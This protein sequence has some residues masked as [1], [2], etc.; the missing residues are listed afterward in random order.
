MSAFCRHSTA[1]STDVSGKLLSSSNDGRRLSY[2]SSKCTTLNN[3]D[4]GRIGKMVSSAGF[5][6]RVSCTQYYAEI[7]VV[8]V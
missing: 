1:C 2:K 6:S 8:L 4:R 3:K 7:A 5:S